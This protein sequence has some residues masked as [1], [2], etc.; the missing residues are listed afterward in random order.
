MRGR[1][2]APERMDID[3]EKERVTPSEAAVHAC[4]CVSGTAYGDD[5]VSVIY[6]KPVFRQ[7]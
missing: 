1:T 6:G 5:C 4:D 3:D 7:V 2:D